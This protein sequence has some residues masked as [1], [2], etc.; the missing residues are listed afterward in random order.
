VF[1]RFTK[2]ARQ[3]VTSA[4]DEA[5]RR[6]D[7]RIGTEHLLIGVAASGGLP[8]PWPDAEA[9]RAQ[10]GRLDEEA[11]RSVGLD[12]DLLENVPTGTARDRR[13]SHLPFTGGAKD[14]LKV[15]L[16]EAIALGHRHIGVEHIA[17]ALASEKGPDRAL[18]VLE[19]LVESP[20]DLRESLLRMMRKAS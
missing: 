15:A 6:G 7:T 1:E 4:V 16:K 5:R 10:L 12:P 13:A 2:E 18:A 20:E 11:L 17:L 9:L 14:I 8:D 3:V 19:G